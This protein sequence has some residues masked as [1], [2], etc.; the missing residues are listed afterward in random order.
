M[1][2]ARAR[3]DQYL[4]TFDRAYY[5]WS[6]Q[7]KLTALLAPLPERKLLRECVNPS[8]I[9]SATGLAQ[10][11]PCPGQN[12]TTDERITADTEIG[13]LV[14]TAAE[15]TFPIYTFGKIAH[16]QNAARAGV[17]IGESGLDYARGQ[18]DFLVKKAY[19]GAQMAETALGIL[20]DGRKRLRKAKR[21]I[22]KELSKDTG[23]FTSNDLRKL[24]VDEAELESGYLETE[25][26]NRQ[27]WAGLRIA[28][29]LPPHSDMK[30]DTLKLRPVHVE[31]RS[32]AEYIELALAA[33]PEV[34][35][36]RAAVRARESQLKMAI[37]DFFPDIALVGGFRFARGTTADDP[38]D[39]FA[40][41]GYNYL[42]WGVVL[43]AEWR[44]DYSVLVSRFKEKQAKLS[45]QR[46][47]YD[48]LIQRVRLNLVEQVSDMD[49][50]RRETDVRRVAM[51]A[52]KAWLISNTLNF[53]MG[54]TT[55]DQLL[56]SLIAYSK[57][58]LTHYRIIYEYNLAVARLSQSVGTELAVPRPSE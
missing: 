13:I 57:A 30:L 25:A 1:A 40:N 26:L 31:R 32:E 3:L 38:V 29:K 53:G 58:R 52:G 10:V 48:A 16:G 34:R 5:A 18:L 2:I 42:G 24:L 14:R 44:I 35:I 37:A 55:V 15:V 54:L 6:P 36:A 49:R 45:Q 21:K 46:A 47:E 17:S 19:Y 39:P 4:A 8:I 20:R 9:D 41:D 33:R 22:E 7:L 11:A 28:A 43:G 23:R 50:R 51:K 27:A 56:K 12:L